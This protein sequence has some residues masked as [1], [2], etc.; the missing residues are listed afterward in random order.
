MIIIFK[1]LVSFRL[2]LFLSYQL[3]LTACVHHHGC[4]AFLYFV[5]AVAVYYIVAAVVLFCEAG[6]TVVMGHLAG[7]EVMVVATARVVA[8]VD[9]FLA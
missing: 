3:F 1:F 9:I 7:R 6:W 2:L 5:G 4:V 8:P